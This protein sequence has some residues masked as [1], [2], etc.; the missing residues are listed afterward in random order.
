M[1]PE[2]AILLRLEIEKLVENSED[3]HWIRLLIQSKAHCLLFLQESQ[4]WHTRDFFGNIFNEEELKKA[5]GSLVFEFEST[6]RPR[7][8]QRRRGYR[9]KGSWRAP[10]EH[11]SYYDG[12]S[13]QLLLEENRSARQDTLVLLQAFLE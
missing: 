1:E 9:D 8:P 4:L 12:T 11:H 6:K 7:L 2:I 13:D 3:L 10:H 5:L